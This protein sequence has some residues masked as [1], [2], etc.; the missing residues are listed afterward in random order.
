MKRSQ[1][2]LVKLAFICDAGAQL[3][4]KLGPYT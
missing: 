3:D 2:H 4:D 1:L